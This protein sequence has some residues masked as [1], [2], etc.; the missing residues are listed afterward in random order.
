MKRFLILAITLLVAFSAAAIAEGSGPVSP[1]STASPLADR[2]DL[3]LADLVQSLTKAKSSFVSGLDVAECNY[4]VE[5]GGKRLSGELTVQMEKDPDMA[6]EPSALRALITKWPDLEKADFRPS[7]AELAAAFLA[8]GA[9]VII[10]PDGSES[11]LVSADKTKVAQSGGHSL[12]KIISLGL[13]I[14]MCPDYIIRDLASM[15]AKWDISKM[16]GHRIEQPESGDPAGLGYEFKI[17]EGGVY[18]T[19][20]EADVYRV[21]LDKASGSPIREDLLSDGKLQRQFDYT[22]YIRMKDGTFAPGK[23]VID[24]QG[25]DWESGDTEPPVSE[26]TFVPTESKWMLTKQM[27]FFDKPGGVLMGKISFGRWRHTKADKTTFAPP[28]GAT[29]IK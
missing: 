5:V 9:T 27:R 22:N 23:I 1:A 25:F 12:L 3:P 28:A 13:N 8:D 20:Y 29:L 15:N 16:T 26:M 7:E 17:P 18:V 10:P 19:P 4:S 11:W 14:C 2:A 24:R 6:G 21:W